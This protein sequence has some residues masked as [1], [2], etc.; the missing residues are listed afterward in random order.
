MQTYKDFNNKINE[1]M[2]F[3]WTE[4]EIKVASILMIRKFGGSFGYE[5]FKELHDESY[6]IK[7]EYSTINFN[8]EIES[9]E[10]LGDEELYDI[11]VSHD[12]LF[13]ANNILTHNSAYGN[14]DAGMESV[15]ESL[16]IM[17]T[18]D[19]AVLL[20][21]SDQMREQ[22]QQLWKFAK[23]RYTG[24]LSSAMIETDFARMSYRSM[25]SDSE[26]STFTP[27]VSEIE[28]GLD[29]GSFQFN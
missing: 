8:D 23:N 5:E 3:G 4:E 28:T 9:I 13:F 18:A 19:V 7:E 21:S 29:L 14:M 6:G 26:G 2:K 20:I 22:H 1:E 15:S 27:N 11:E 17:M 10:Y 16:K 24:E 12:N 25:D